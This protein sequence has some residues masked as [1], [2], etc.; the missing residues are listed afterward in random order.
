V[1]TA[2]TASIARRLVREHKPD[3]ALVGYM[4]PDWNG[5]ELGVEFLASMPQM[6]IVVMSASILPPVDEA[7][8]VEHNFPFLGKPFVISDFVRELKKLENRRA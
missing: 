8:C 2:E 4:L 5:V 7:L 6:H 1:F 3:A